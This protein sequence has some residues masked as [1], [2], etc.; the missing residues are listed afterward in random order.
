MHKPAP[1][2]TATD[3]IQSLVDKVNHSFR[4]RLHTY[5]FILILRRNR[6]DMI[7]TYAIFTV[8]YVTIFSILFH[9]AGSS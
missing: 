6:L 7:D 3:E 2:M 1:G 8:I 9:A 4:N 5:A